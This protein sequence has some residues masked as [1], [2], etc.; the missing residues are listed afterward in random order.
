MTRAVDRLLESPAGLRAR[1]AVRL[2]EAETYP[3]ASHERRRQI[4]I[5]AEYER[6]A[7]ERETK[8]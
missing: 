5:A 3:A 8:Q 2:Q 6:R 1:A 7:T 4:L